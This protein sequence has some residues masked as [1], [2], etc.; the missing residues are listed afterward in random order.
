PPVLSW[1]EQSRKPPPNRSP[2]EP[3][4]PARIHQVPLPFAA[5]QQLL[6]VSVSVPPQ[7][8]LHAAPHRHPVPEER[9]ARLPVRPSAQFPPRG[10]PPPPGRG[11]PP[12]RPPRRPQPHHSTP[13]AASAGP[14]RDAGAD[15]TPVPP[16]AGAARPAGRHAHRKPCRTPRWRPQGTGRPWPPV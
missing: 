3:A 13:T 4:K 2:Q 6:S 1:P 11:P 12:Y 8:P 15:G 10:P 7:L 16:P 5:A 14:C 9:A